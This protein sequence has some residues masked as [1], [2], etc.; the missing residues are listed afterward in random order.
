MSFFEEWNLIIGFIITFYTIGTIFFG[1]FSEN[2]YNIVN[3]I[4]R[5]LA[6]LKNKDV[7]IRLAFS[8]LVNNSFNEVK[9][10]IIKQFENVDVK[11]ET[12]T[13]IDFTSGTYSVSIIQN[14]RNN[15]FIEIERIGC[16][17][18]GLKNKI[19]ELLGKLNNLSTGNKPI[20]EKFLACDIDITL[21]FVWTYININQP[22]KFNIKRYIIELEEGTFKSQVKIIMDKI[23]IKLNTLQAIQPILE[24]FI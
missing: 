9:K 20:L 5:R 16:G 1:V 17:I 15:I 13:K 12:K 21:P 4:K 19:L 10:E 18:K 7:I 23:N 8:Y 2:R 22:K 3:R 24:K 6:I 14:S 11:R